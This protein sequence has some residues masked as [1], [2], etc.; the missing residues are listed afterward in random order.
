MLRPQNGVSSLRQECTVRQPDR[1]FAAG[2]D[3]QF[4][5]EPSTLVG[6]SYKAQVCMVHHVN[7]RQKIYRIHEYTDVASLMR[8]AAPR[9]WSFIT[10]GTRTVS[11]KPSTNP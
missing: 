7:T 2:S 11:E 8:P 5:V 9:G 1:R 4:S 3:W 10:S 6:H